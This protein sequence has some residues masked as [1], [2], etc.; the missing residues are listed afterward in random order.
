MSLVNNVDLPTE[1]KPIMPTR[2]SPAFETSKPSPVT[3]LPPDGSINY[4][5]SL[6]NLALSR[7]TW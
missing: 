5:L 3:F 1:G 2:A 6:A 4:L 7:P